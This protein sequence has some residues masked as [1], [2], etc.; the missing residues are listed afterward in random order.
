MFCYSSSLSGYHRLVCCGTST[1]RKDTAGDGAHE[2]EEDMRKLQ[3][4]ATSSKKR[5]LYEVQEQLKKRVNLSNTFI[6]V[7]LMQA[8]LLVQ[9][10]EKEPGQA[11]RDD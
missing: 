5:S 4:Q 11:L 7:I 6:T 8:S 9:K 1:D 2:K 3:L 10:H